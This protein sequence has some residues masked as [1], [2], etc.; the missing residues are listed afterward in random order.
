[1]HIYIK[2]YLL[3]LI[4]YVKYYY[5]T[6]SINLYLLFILKNFNHKKLHTTIILINK[7]IS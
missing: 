7:L 3:I 1:M 6:L 5:I 2:Y 4:F